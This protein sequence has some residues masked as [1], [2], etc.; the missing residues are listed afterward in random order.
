MKY[1]GYEIVKRKYPTAINP[2][3][4]AYDIMDGDRVRKANISTIE[5][6]K[7]VIDAMIKWNFWQDKSST[8]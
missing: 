1:K 5:T 8:I 7:H 6:A 2:N 3:R 4:E